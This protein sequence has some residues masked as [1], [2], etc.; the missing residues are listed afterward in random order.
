MSNERTAAVRLFQSGDALSRIHGWRPLKG[1]PLSGLVNEKGWAC[2]HVV[3]QKLLGEGITQAPQDLYDQV[4]IF[5][6]PGAIVV[7]Q[8]GDKVGLVRSYR[9]TAERLASL[10]E[11]NKNYLQRLAQEERWDELLQ[12]LGR[13]QWELPRGLAPTAEGLDLQKFILASARVEASEEGGFQ[14]DNARICG[15][16]NPNSTFF[17]H[18]QYVVRGDIV[19]VGTNRPEQLELIGK[20]QLFGKDEL[21]QLTDAGEFDDGLSLAAFALSGYA[22]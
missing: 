2:L 4:M 18:S 17:A 13:W 20:A 6:N 16:V 11:S 22:F 10:A 9:F 15:R 12:S 5:E 8:D 19:R 7:C 14:I 3:V 1:D 21:R